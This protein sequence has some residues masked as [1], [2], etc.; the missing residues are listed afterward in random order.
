MRIRL[1]LVTAVVTALSVVMAASPAS[2]V[3]HSE[4]V[5][6]LLVADEVG[7]RWHTVDASRGSSGDLSGCESA[8]Y[9]RR[10]VDAKA[11]RAFRFGKS[12]SFITEKLTAFDTTRL[13]RRDF[14]KGVELFSACEEFTI[15]GTPFSVHRVNLGDFADQRAGFKIRGTVD[16][17]GEFVPITFFLVTTRW[18]HQIVATTMVVEGALTGDQ[19]RTV[20]ASTV[21]VAK[22]ATEKVDNVLGR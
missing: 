22:V 21:R 19:V 9:T 17:D 6:A 18:G 10:G 1:L 11:K 3:T 20:K 16:R 4:A 5:S 15:D 2:A 12:A 13:A 8:Q 7:N 14:R